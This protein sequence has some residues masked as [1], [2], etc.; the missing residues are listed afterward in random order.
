MNILTQR[1][2]DIL[3]I[4][5]RRHVGLTLIATELFRKSEDKPFDPEI[6]VNNSV[7]RI[8][9]KCN[10]HKLDWTLERNKVN[11]KL[12]IKKIKMEV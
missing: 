4:I 11:N 12:L 8:I 2:R 9:K 1:E 7:K 3:K 10:H 6:T 5:G